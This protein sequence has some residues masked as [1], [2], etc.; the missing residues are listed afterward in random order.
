MTDA[1]KQL[2]QRADTPPAPARRDLASRVRKR[3]ARGRAVQSSAVALLIALFAI[4]SMTI[5]RHPQQVATVSSSPASPAPPSVRLA[6][7]LDERIHELTA[8]RLLASRRPSSTRRP[9]DS[10]LELQHQRDRAALFIVYEGERCFK[11]NRPAD[12]IASYR[13]AIELFPQTH[14][15]DV[16]RRRLSEM[17]T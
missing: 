2:L 6:P 14:W 16:A 17:Q 13:R 9:V 11:A 10:T 5:R 7:T 15:A 8:E 4:M 1:L 12:A 3:H